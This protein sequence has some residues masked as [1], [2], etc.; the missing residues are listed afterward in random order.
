MDLDVLF[1]GTAGSAPTARRGLPA[2]L[3][4]RGGDRLLFDCGE[5]TQRQLLRSVGLLEL[6]E[7]FIS[8]FHA[9]HFLGLPGLLKT[10]SLRGR[11]HPLTIYGPPRLG[12][13]FDAMLPVMGKTAFE[14]RI[15][16]LEPN[17]E[18][19]RDGYRVAAFAVEHRVLAYGYA[20]IEE[21]RPGRFDEARARE[22]GVT[23]GPNF[24]RLQEGE[25]VTGS[26]GEVRP[27]QVL[28]EARRGRKVVIAGDTAPAEMTVVV[29]HR[30]DLLVHEATFS[31]EDAVR[32]RETG[33][34]T[35]RDAAEL[36]KRAEVRL[37]AL[38]HISQRYAGPE[39]RDEAREVFPNTIV[40]RDFDRVEIP[41]PERGEPIHHKSSPNGG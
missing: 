19:W 32:A 11:E 34:T 21:E 8:H 17:Q 16:E 27:E 24:G 38:N 14:V 4:R 5:G 7:I 13:L 39:L 10:F 37:L 36:A 23:P 26:S 6:E 22:L 15:V 28:G 35:A 3:V 1:L 31:I 30:A 40:P 29:A 18:L 25:T 33:H 9:D 20:L 12:A 2:T 41:F